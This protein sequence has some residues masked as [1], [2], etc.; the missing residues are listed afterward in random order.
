MHTINNFLL[1]S[2]CVLIR[3]TKVCH[4][5]RTNI[6]FYPNTKEI[7]SPLENGLVRLKL[8]ILWLAN[9]KGY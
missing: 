7:E 3:K 6:F 8:C 1:V 4:R 5:V 2:N 9:L